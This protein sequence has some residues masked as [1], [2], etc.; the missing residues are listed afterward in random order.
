MGVPCGPRPRWAHTPKALI[1]TVCL[2]VWIQQGSAQEVSFEVVDAILGDVVTLPAPAVAD[3]FSYAWYRGALVVNLKSICTYFISPPKEVTGDEY[4]G[5]ETCQPVGSLQIRGLLAN[6]SGNYTIHV[7]P[8][9]QNPVQGIRLL[10]VKEKARSPPISPSSS[11]GLSVGYI[12]D[13]VIGVLA[14]F[15]IVAAAARDSPEMAP[16]NKEYSASPKANRM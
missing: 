7:Q 14:V 12:V 9:R 8:M 10:R 11:P 1:L 13:I 6:Y 15:I 4:T 3:V 2:G 5:R 16:N